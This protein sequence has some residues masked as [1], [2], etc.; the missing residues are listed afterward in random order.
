MST[1]QDN[2]AEELSA[3]LSMLRGAAPAG[4]FFDLRW[5][6]SAGRM[7]RRFLPATSSPPALVRV[8][9]RM[10]ARG[11]VYVGVALRESS[12][13]GGRASIGS[14]HLAFLESDSVATGQRLLA[15]PRPPSMIVAS[16]SSGH[17]HVYW[18]LDRL[19]PALL[20]EAAN[21]RLALALQGDPSSADAARILR[22]P[23][24]SNYKHT[25]PAPVRLLASR[26]EL[27]YSL[28]ALS[29]G[30][31]EDPHDGGRSERE[32]R[33]VRSEVDRDL[34]AV[35]AAQY[36]RVLSGRVPDREGKIRCPFHEDRHPS[37]QLYG[38][39]G[40]YCFGAGCGAGGSIFDFASRLWGI[41][42]RGAG[43]LELRRRLSEVLAM[44]ARGDA[45]PPDAAAVPPGLTPTP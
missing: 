22:P 5:R 42:P 39:G 14:T 34:L 44:D 3:Y 15:F 23:G 40:F 8:I 32:R 19:Y 25:P 13:H 27:T 45:C 37:L 17:V 24:T 20:V 28:A 33:L 21:R 6:T 2:S 38:D 4:R 41:T 16:G 36:V 43:F 10:G 35:P 12:S 11:D 26:R 1:E 18:Q 31:P 7:R 30:L 29:H 9:S